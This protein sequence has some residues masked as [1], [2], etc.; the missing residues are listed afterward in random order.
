M[1]ANAKLAAAG[2]QVIVFVGADKAQ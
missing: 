2:A 1:D